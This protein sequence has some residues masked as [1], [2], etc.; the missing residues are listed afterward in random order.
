M[1]MDC[2]IL[3]SHVMTKIELINAL[4]EMPDHAEIVL[5]EPFSVVRHVVDVKATEHGYIVFFMKP[6]EAKT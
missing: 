6:R 2:Y 3:C 1:S 5:Q 4:K